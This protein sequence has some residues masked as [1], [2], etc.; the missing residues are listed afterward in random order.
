M[1]IT[2]KLGDE[3]PQLSASQGSN[4]SDVEYYYFHTFRELSTAANRPSLNQLLRD[5]TTLT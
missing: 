5:S 3:T 4:A 1:A 2:H